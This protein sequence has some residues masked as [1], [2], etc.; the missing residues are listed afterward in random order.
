MV[1]AGC[2]AVSCHN[3]STGVP[4]DESMLAL[5]S[6]DAREKLPKARVAVWLPAT[7][8]RMPSHSMSVANGS[9]EWSA[10]VGR[11]QI[12]MRGDPLD[13]GGSARIA[14][15]G[16][17]QTHVVRGRMVT[18]GVTPASTSR[19]WSYAA[20]WVESNAVYS[21]DVS[22]RPGDVACD[23]NEFVLQLIHDLVLVWSAPR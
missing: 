19:N 20:R 4:V 23:T 1:A 3:R 15:L 21:V 16:D 6:S 11:V 8:A 12:Q 2:L 13:A 9:Y 14:V 7:L 5:L 18:L 22:C 17:I 10:S